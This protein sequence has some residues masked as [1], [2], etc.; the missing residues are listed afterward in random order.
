MNSLVRGGL[1]RVEILNQSGVGVEVGAGRVPV[2]RRRQLVYTFLGP[3]L[4]SPADDDL[5][6]VDLV[7]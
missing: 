1:L 7:V 3:Q 5:L 2:Q 6:R 4:Y